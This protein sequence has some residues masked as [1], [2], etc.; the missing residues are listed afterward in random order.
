MIISSISVCALSPYYHG[1]EH[2]M[3]DYTGYLQ[4]TKMAKIKA[5]NVEKQYGFLGYVMKYATKI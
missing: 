5:E 1:A 4:T 2:T 3:H